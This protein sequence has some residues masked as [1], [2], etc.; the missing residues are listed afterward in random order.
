MSTPVKEF[1]HRSYSSSDLLEDD[2]IQEHY[3]QN[4]ESDM[5]HSIPQ[6]LN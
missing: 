2:I 3:I 6:P 1:D 4:I 5:H